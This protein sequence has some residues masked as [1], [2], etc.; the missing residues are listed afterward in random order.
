MNGIVEAGNQAG[1]II[2]NRGIQGRERHLKG[3]ETLK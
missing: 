2:I 1:A 3:G